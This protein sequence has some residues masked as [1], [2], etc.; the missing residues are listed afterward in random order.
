[1]NSELNTS[2]QHKKKKVA[3][4]GF[5]PMT[6]GLWAQHASPAIF[7]VIYLLLG[8]VSY[9]FVVFFDH[10]PPSRCCIIALL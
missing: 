1:M 9:D 3:A 6:F 5:D 4:I 10:I 2:T 7:I 8:Y